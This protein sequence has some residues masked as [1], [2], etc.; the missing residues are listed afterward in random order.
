[1]ELL[2]NK[3]FSPKVV[4]F[5]PSPTAPKTF[6]PGNDQPANRKFQLLFTSPAG[7]GERVRS[8]GL[9]K[10]LRFSIPKMVPQHFPRDVKM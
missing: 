1:M 7:T 6:V 3:Q 10:G 2:S 8:G 4:H 9:K 5:E